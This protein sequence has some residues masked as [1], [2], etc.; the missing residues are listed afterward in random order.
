MMSEQRTPAARP[1]TPPE[2]YDRVRRLMRGTTM[3]SRFSVKNHSLL[4]V[5]EFGEKLD[6]YHYLD[7]DAISIDEFDEWCT[8]ANI[9]DPHLHAIAR[10]IV[11]NHNVIHN[12]ADVLDPSKFAVLCCPS[13]NKI[14]IVGPQQGDVDCCTADIIRVMQLHWPTTTSASAPLHDG[15]SADV[16]GLLNI[17]VPP[18]ITTITSPTGLDITVDSGV[19][20]IKGTRPTVPHMFV[21][22]TTLSGIKAVCAL[23]RLDVDTVNTIVLCSIDHYALWTEHK[24]TNMTVVCDTVQLNQQLRDRSDR[25]AWHRVVTAG[26]PLVHAY[27]TIPVQWHVVYAGDPRVD[28]IVGKVY[29]PGRLKYA[30]H[31]QAYRPTTTPVDYIKLLHTL[32]ADEVDKSTLALVKAVDEAYE[33]IESGVKHTIGDPACPLQSE[34][35]ICALDAT[36]DVIDEEEVPDQNKATLLCGHTFHNSCITTW[37]RV[38]ASPTC[39]MC[40][41]EDTVVICGSATINARNLPAWIAGEGNVLEP[42]IRRTVVMC[43]RLAAASFAGKPGYSKITEVNRGQLW[44]LHQDLW[45]DD[46]ATHIY[47]VGFDIDGSSL[48]RDAARALLLTGIGVDISTEAVTIN[49]TH[50]CGVRG[51]RRLAIYRLLRG[52]SASLEAEFAPATP[53]FRTVSPRPHHNMAG[54]ALSLMFMVTNSDDDEF[55]TD[56][57]VDGS[58]IEVIEVDELD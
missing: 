47:S 7:N 17:E 55:E 50:A 11:I 51:I 49:E 16:A 46:S 54:S 30:Y 9:P 13:T 12:D 43:S 23:A 24:T 37:L 26:R 48:D 27:R 57:E 28:E 4:A 45:N 41:A 53:Y 14:N 39:P 3:H 58:Q 38:G 36:E 56:D 40:R 34:C 44:G 52:L 18:A 21:P 8:P 42:N 29:Q 20:S 35:V 6:L 2:V 32:W 5:I 25:V 1:P 15:L 19:C 31:C 22:T 10:T 33:H